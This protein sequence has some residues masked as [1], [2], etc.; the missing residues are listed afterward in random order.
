MGITG[1]T[2][3]QQ[4]GASIARPYAPRMRDIETVDSELRLMVLLRHAARERG[5]PL[6]S[7]D[8]ADPLLDECCELTG[9]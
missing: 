3:R 9:S 4:R 1:S 6:P 7:I 8:V 2:S 5:E